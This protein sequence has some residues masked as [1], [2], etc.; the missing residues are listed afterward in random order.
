MT[1]RTLKVHPSQIS[2]PIRIC[3]QAIS[4]SIKLM[5]TNIHLLAA[6]LKQITFSKLGKISKVEVSK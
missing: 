4:Y 2:S 5:K 3:Y 6:A 1:S